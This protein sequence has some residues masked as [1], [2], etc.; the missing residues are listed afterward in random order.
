MPTLWDLA[1]C[2]YCILLWT[3]CTE[4]DDG[5]PVRGDD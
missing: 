4:E 3:L 1:F 2:W 5:T